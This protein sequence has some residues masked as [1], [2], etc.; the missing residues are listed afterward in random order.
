[1]GT[2]DPGEIA[3]LFREPVDLEDVYSEAIE[4]WDAC[5]QPDIVDKVLQFYTKI[6]LQDDILTKVDRASMMHS[7]EVRAPYLD[8]ELVDFVRTIPH[9]Y[10]YRNGVTKYIL[11]K[12][13]EPVLPHNILYRPK[14]GFG[15]PIGSWF[16]RGMLEFHAQDGAGM[17]D[18]QFIRRKY[19]AHSAGRSDERAF[20]WNAWQLQQWQG[21]AA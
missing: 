20:L 13:L 3:A 11:K 9:R 10:K 2:L 6:Y 4:Q 16:R 19:E 18:P 1:M 5:K 8:I 15:V 7:L 12:A 21:N 14:K 17:L